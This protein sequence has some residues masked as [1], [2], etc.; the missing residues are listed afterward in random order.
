MPDRHHQWLAHLLPSSAHEW[1]T[2]ALHDLRATC[3]RQRMAHSAIARRLARIRFV[4]GAV[5]LYIE[6]LWLW[7]I[8]PK[9]HGARRHVSPHPSPRKEVIAMWARDVRHAFRLFRREP[10]FCAAAVL[11]LAL[12]IGVNTSL[13]AVVEAV[14]LRPLP[15]QESS[16]LIMLEH[17]DLRTGIK[18]DFVA[19]GDVI[20]LRYRQHSLEALVAFSNLQS[21]LIDGMDPIRLEGLASTAELF[22][23]LRVEPAL[24]RFLEP[25]DMRDAAPPVVVI[26]HE[27]WT[28]RFGSSLDIVGRSVQIGSARR[29]VVGVAPRGLRFPPAATT[30][31]IIPFK[32]PNSAPAE[33]RA[34]IHAMGRMRNGVTIAETNAEL[35]TLSRQFEQEFPGSNQGTR[36]NALSL[37]DAMVGDT[38]R[39]LLLL[40]G[41]VAFV[42]L[43][44][45]V[46][47]GNLLLARSLSR[48]QEMAMRLALGAGKWRVVQQV[49]AEALVLATTGSALGVVVAWRFAPL[50]ATIVPRSAAVPGL[51]DV[52]INTAVLAFSLAASL[53]ATLL[54]G[55]I[56]A[57]GLSGSS[58]AH[59]ATRRTTMSVGARRVASTLV[60]G[61]V[62]LAIVLVMGAALTLRSF[63][64]LIS[65]DPGFTPSHVLNVQIALPPGRYPNDAARR[66]VFDRSFAALAAV[67]GVVTA[68]AGVVTPLTGN[69][70]TIPLV[71][72][73]RPL[74]SGERP[75]DVGWQAASEG[76]FRALRI[77][78]RAGR[79]FDASDRPGSKPVVIVSEGLASQYFAGENAVGQQVMLGKE[80]AEIVGVV[81]DIRRAALSDAP[82]ADM[83]LPF[84]R[85]PSQAVGLFIRTEDD[86]LAALPAIR[87]AIRNIEPNA[88]LYG[89]E[90]LDRVAAESAAVARIAMQLLGGFAVMA[91]LLAA[92]GIYGVMSY[93]VRR[94]TREL[95]TR[96][97][98]GATRQDIHRLV[99]RQA[100]TIAVAG[101][102][103]GIAIGLAAARSLNAI[104]Y[105]VPSWDPLAIAGALAVLALTTAAAGYLPARRAARIDPA[106]TLAAD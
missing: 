31:V 14:L 17:E 39:P 68:G 21:T 60:A 27:L 1:F 67:P 24:G 83:Y 47:V 92:I 37:R 97:A 64:R 93:S 41:A 101:S 91:V 78:L 84:E 62:A 105:G 6:C 81:G 22:Q 23:V 87:T 28:T 7:V 73:E 29:T 40:L 95:G 10:A 56:A 26:S 88:L 20:D 89:A 32:L 50:L 77:P 30:D 104:L 85:S 66:D 100:G 69:N 90:S 61:E 9:A 65:V 38:K 11:T 55:T 103:I 48:Q 44:A 82:H 5:W 4:V 59:V 106:T 86:P 49:I 54:F 52:T 33:R 12:G 80:P 46:N 58:G 19:M 96:V 75:P 99:M 76:Y 74:E 18:K 34:W 8:A 2:P 102:S 42:L 35:S 36:Y 79:F 94:R 57:I 72:P 70:W 98:L 16:Q 71:R 43:I 45:C 51:S 15:Y 3:A 53:L 25:D 13:F 63:A